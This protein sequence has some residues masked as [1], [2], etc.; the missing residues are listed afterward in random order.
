LLAENFSQVASNWLEVKTSFGGKL[1]PETLSRMRRKSVVFNSATLA[2][3]MH[4]T[5][6]DEVA[7]KDHL[8]ESFGQSSPSKWSFLCPSLYSIKRPE[9]SALR[10]D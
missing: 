8:P 4:L 10:P 3:L 6:A 1:L 2:P 5:R 9:R 7:H